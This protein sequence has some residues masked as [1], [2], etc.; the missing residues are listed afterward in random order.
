MT[1]LSIAKSKSLNSLQLGQTTVP[2][3]M[4]TLFAIACGMLA[5]NVYYSQPIAGPI[6]ASLGLSPG[7]TGFIVTLT[8]VGFGA[9]LLFIVP[10]ADLV[11]NRALV[12]TLTGMSAVALLGAALSAAPLVYVVPAV[13]VGLGSV[14]VQ[15]L[16][17]FAALV[18]DIKHKGV[19]ATTGFVR[20]LN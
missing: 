17:P 2:F 19:P 12:V 13:F 8:Q 11:E 5:A 3:R 1:M 18:E 10:L 16:I 4:M 20:K 7:L 6:A 14:A 15:V 9:G